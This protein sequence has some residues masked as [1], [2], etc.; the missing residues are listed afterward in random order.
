MKMKTGYLTHGE[1]Q[2]YIYIIHGTDVNKKVKWIWRQALS[3][4][5]RVSNKMCHVIA[6]LNQRHPTPA[7][8]PSWN[9]SFF[10]V[11]VSPAMKPIHP[12]AVR[13][14]VWKTS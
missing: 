7:F 5:Q 4:P 12:H 3:I 1:G 9:K 10:F 13:P 11:K 2:E 6:K 14:W 8:Q